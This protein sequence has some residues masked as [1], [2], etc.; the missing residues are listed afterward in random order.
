MGIPFL[1]SLLYN[2][3]HRRCVVLEQRRIQLYHSLH[4]SKKNVREN[5]GGI[6][7]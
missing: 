2:T 3:K 5:K 4:I 7:K 6:K 1:K